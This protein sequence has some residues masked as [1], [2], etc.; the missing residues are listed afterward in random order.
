QYPPSVRLHWFL[1][2]QLRIQDLRYKKSPQTHRKSV[3]LR[4]WNLPEPS[5]VPY[6]SVPFC[7]V[8]AYATFQKSFTLIYV[9]SRKTVLLRKNPLSKF[10]T[11]FSAKHFPESIYHPFQKNCLKSFHHNSCQNLICI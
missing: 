2:F 7:L 10:S 8:P 3:W 6:Q 9:F 4:Y 1:S 5:A 11:Y